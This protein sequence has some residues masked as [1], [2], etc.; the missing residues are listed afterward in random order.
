MIVIFYILVAAVAAYLTFRSVTNGMT[1]IDPRD[2]PSVIAKPAGA[3]IVTLI[4]FGIQPFTL[5][6]IDNGNVGLKVSRIGNDR[7]VGNYEYKSGI[8][9]YN[10]WTSRIVEV[11]ITQQQVHYEKQI[12]TTYG[13]YPADIA[14]SFNYSAK[15][16]SVG[17][18]YTELK[19]PLSE[20]EKKW[21]NTAVVTAINDVSNRWKIDSIFTK[22]QAFEIEIFKEINT[23]VGKWFTLSQLRTNMVPPDDLIE[24]I[25]NK[26]K[27]VQEIQVAEQR[28]KVADAE[29]YTRRAVAKADSIVLVTRAAAEAKA[30]NLRQAVLTPML[31]RQQWIEAWEKGGSK[32]P[33]YVG[34]SGQ[35]QIWNMGD[36]KE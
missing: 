29:G 30:N 11:P 5:E 7:G 21:L 27:A 9:I 16:G 4:L 34:G 24:T 10:T 15:P 17:E 23:K 25:R 22:R 36:L 20:I 14:P 31:L 19:Q 1:N 6:I 8:V 28:K 18:M 32:V 35:G 33:V 12:V 3:F 13:G 26:T 2:T